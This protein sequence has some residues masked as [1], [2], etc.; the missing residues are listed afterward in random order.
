M[1]NLKPCPF[2]GGKAAA[3]EPV[4][5]EWVH[6]LCPSCGT[7]SDYYDDEEEAIE[8]WNTRAERTCKIKSVGLVDEFF[9]AY[10]L[11]CGHQAMEDEPSYCPVCGAKVVE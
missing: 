7:E 4:S 10:D 8:A 11:S 6:V 1:K 3:F 5:G 9:I 2:C